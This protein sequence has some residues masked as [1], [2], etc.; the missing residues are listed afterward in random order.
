MIAGLDGGCVLGRGGLTADVAAGDRE[1][2][3]LP[4]RCG[5]SCAGGEAEGLLDG[6]VIDV[7]MG[8]PVRVGTDRVL[9]TVP[10]STPFM[11]GRLSD[12]SSFWSGLSAATLG[13]TARTPSI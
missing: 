10:C 3:V 7:T 11:P 5:A 2:D 6:E 4:C 8:P 1:R 13:S 9:P 12:R